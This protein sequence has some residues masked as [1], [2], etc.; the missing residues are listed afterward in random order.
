MPCILFG[1]SGWSCRLAQ[2]DG[3]EPLL[4]GFTCRPN[5]KTGSCGEVQWYSGRVDGGE[6]AERRVGECG[7]RR[8]MWSRKANLFALVSMVG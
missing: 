6:I 4:G 5:I 7:R 2:Q 8:D 1:V 3:R